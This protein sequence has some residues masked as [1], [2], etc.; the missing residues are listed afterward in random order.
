MSIDW[1]AEVEKRQDALLE[2]LF[3]M[4]KIESVRDES[5]A[6]T[7]APLGPGPKAG[8]DKFLEIGTR[9]GFETLNLDGLAGHIE[10]GEGDETLGILAHVDVMPAGN[11]WDTDPFTPVVKDGRIYA[12][13]ASDDKGPGMAAYYGLKIIQELG[14]PV[15][16]KVRFII[17]TDEESGWRGMTHYL[18]NMPEPDFGFSPDAFFP[19]INGEKGNITYFLNF[20]GSNGDKDQLLEFDAGLRENMVPRDAKAV[21]KTEYGAEMEEVFNDFIA[22]NIVTGKMERNNDIVTISMVGKAAHAQEPKN[23]ENAGTF[24]ALFLNQFNFGGDAA[25]YLRLAA[26]YLHRDSRMNNFSIAF[27]DDIMGDLTMNSGIFTFKA[28]KGG[29]IA[30]NFRFPKGMTEVDIKRG[31]ENVTN[32]MN[33]AIEAGR[34]QG[35]HYVSPEDPLVK[36][37][38]G[39]YT[40]QTGEKAEGLVVGGGTYGRLLKRGVAF[41][42]M[43]PGVPDTMHQANEFIPLDDVF[44]AAAIYAE[45]IYELIK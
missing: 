20:K 44:K 27:T 6:T 38:L 28:D 21:I 31:L 3:A 41:G 30:L 34:L 37:L 19:I 25:N 29:Q 16:K 22:A 26:D 40:K 39:V 43:F 1:K 18:E 13:G 23:G 32:E 12:R 17:G 5:I 2:D 42:A 45:G 10:F 4:L 9:D 14:L 15:S 36:T 8:L 11:G 33:V 7:E 24:L 35:P